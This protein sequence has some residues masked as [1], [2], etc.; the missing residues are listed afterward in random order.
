MRH[1]ISSTLAAAL[2]GSAVVASTFLLAEDPEGIA[3]YGSSSERVALET[4][5]SVVALLAAYLVFGRFRQTR[6]L[7]DLLLVCALELTAFRTVFFAAIPAV[8]GGGEGIVTLARSSGG[9]IAAATF[10]AAAFAPARPVTRHRPALLL[11]ALLPVLTAAAAAAVASAP[12]GRDEPVHGAVLALQLVAAAFF[13]A[14]AAGLARRAANEADELLGWVAAAAAVAACARV[15]YF[16][17]PP[18]DTDRVHVGDVLRLSVYVMLLVGALR[19]IQGYWRKAA[20]AAKLE[21]RQR[22]ARDLHDGLAQELAFLSTQ[23]RRLTRAPLAPEMV[24]H[25]ATAA[26]RALNESRR[27]V[28]AL[29]RPDGLPFELALVQAAE[30]VAGRVGAHVAVEVDPDVQPTD[31]DGEELIRIVQEAVTNAVRHGRARVVRIQL[32]SSP[33]RLRVVDDG[34]GFDPRGADSAGGFG[35]A[36]MSQRAERLGGRFRADSRPGAGTTIEV[37]FS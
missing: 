8:A 17:T 4:A 7:D 12:A 10:A 18:L 22:I 19:E 31:A 11:V 36:S 34:V 37:A 28:N 30:E 26:E 35:L 24:Q 6:R 1:P 25:L 13:A 33:L 5:A 20:H 2:V 23:T 3:G 27:A 15:S 21:E 9:I 14:A 16:L 29:T 32:T